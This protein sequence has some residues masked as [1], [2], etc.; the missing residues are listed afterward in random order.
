[1]KRAA[2]LLGPRDLEE[3]LGVRLDAICLRHAR[4]RL[5]F[6]FPTWPM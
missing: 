6:P 1:M 4:Y 2:L 5:P 3:G